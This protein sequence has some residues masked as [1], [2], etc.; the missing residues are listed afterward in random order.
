MLRDQV[1]ASVTQPWQKA[2][3]HQ[4]YKVKGRSRGA[5]FYVGA[6][7]THPM[8]GGAT[9]LGVQLL[10]ISTTSSIKDSGGKDL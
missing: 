2:K 6:V 8:D 1:S 9:A 7:A 4:V 10:L 3:S 5:T